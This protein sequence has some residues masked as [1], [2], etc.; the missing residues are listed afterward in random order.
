[1]PEKPVDDASKEEKDL[2]ATWECDNESTRH[3]LL[4]SI[5]NDLVK[6]FEQ[7][8]ATKEINDQIIVK[9]DAS[10]VSRLMAALS[11]YVNYKMLEGTSIND[12]FDQ[13]NIR[14]RNLTAL[15]RDMDQEL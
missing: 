1:M 7:L 10:T 2:Y 5:S 4:I 11:N 12:H 15:E 8:V 3:L 14:L 6:Q 9:Y 13:M